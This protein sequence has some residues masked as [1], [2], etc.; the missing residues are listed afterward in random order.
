MTRPYKITAA[1]VAVL[2]LWFA[3]TLGMAWAQQAARL[4]VLPTAGK[5]VGLV[6]TA[7]SGRWFVLGPRLAPVQSQAFRLSAEAGGG[8]IIFWEGDPGSEYTVLFVPDNVGEGLAATAVQ[9][10]GAVPVIPVDPFDPTPPPPVT[11]EADQVVIVTESTESLSA[12]QLQIVNGEEVRS[13]ASAAGLE[14]RAVDKDVTGPDLQRIAHVLAAVQ[15]QPVPRLV[16]A[17]AGKVID[18][19]P[20]PAT[21]AATVARIKQFAKRS[22]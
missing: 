18:N 15:G 13:A 7:S 20:L 16:F 3:V 1:C 14:F 2:V 11:G 10:G 12:E 21:P 6:R 9:L 19:Q 8:S 22:K 4:D 5:S 17:K